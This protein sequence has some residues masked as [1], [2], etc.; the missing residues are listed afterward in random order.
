MEFGG[1]N[2]WTKRKREREE[3][4]RKW[5]DELNGAAINTEQRRLLAWCTS[6]EIND[7]PMFVPFKLYETIF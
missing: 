1:G 3:L 6:E 4:N 5:N 7:S 2:E